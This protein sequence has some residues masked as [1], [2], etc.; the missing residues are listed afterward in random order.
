MSYSSRYWGVPNNILK[1]CS[2]VEI[3]TDGV[4]VEGIYS[5]LALAA[6]AAL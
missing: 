6:T 4:R 2:K 1:H 5:L 3:I